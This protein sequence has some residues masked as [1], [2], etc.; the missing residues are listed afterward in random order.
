MRQP[1]AFTLFIILILSAT[2]FRSIAADGLLDKDVK[3]R[4]AAMTA[5]RDKKD[6][7]EISRLFLST[8]FLERKAASYAIRVFTQKG[9]P[10]QHEA[11]K[12]ILIKS[13]KDV[14][15]II[16]FE[17]AQTLATWN[18]GQ[19]NTILIENL[20]HSN[21]LRRLQ[22]SKAL[23]LTADKRAIPHLIGNLRDDNYD[24]RYAS[25][26]TLRKITGDYYGYNPTDPT[27]VVLSSAQQKQLRQ[28]YIDLFDNSDVVANPDKLNEA[29]AA[30]NKACE[31]MMKTH[32][33]K[34]DKIRELAIAQ[35]RKWWV[36][37]QEGKRLD[38]LKTGLEHQNAAT[39]QMA[40]ESLVSIDAIIAHSNIVEKLQDEDYHV[41]EAACKALVY[42][43]KTEAIQ[44]LITLM[45]ETNDPKGGNEESA[46]IKNFN[47][48]FALKGITQND[49]GSLYTNWQV[50]W[51]LNKKMFKVFVDLPTPEGFNIRL[52]EVGETPKFQVKYYYTL[53]K[54]WIIKE[55]PVPLNKEVGQ[56]NQ[57]HVFIDDDGLEIE[58]Y[59]DFRTG[60]T[61][62][63]IDGNTVT[64]KLAD[65]T[66]EKD[67]EEHLIEGEEFK[68]Q[69]DE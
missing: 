14:S 41:V 45:E 46:N 57:K 51:D 19:G 7:N 48:Y 37:N 12:E 5:L 6:L 29:N 56:R 21:P 1:I 38:W 11:A 67:G 20:E 8:E 13:L 35:W 27:N 52:L 10:D 60:L 49:L 42:F 53:E 55:Y 2:P 25:V 22:A 68:I 47:G 33:A 58:R 50:W 32:I 16:R 30:Y 4:K 65:E 18:D 62:I 17:S 36:D 26:H 66:F 28:T 64:L 54:T 44:P 59:F 63:A 39:R 34:Y 23:F 69:L 9:V 3:K 24:T 31:D 15:P 40:I 43:K 61:L